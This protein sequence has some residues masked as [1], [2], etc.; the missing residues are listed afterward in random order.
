MK[1]WPVN[2]EKSEWWPPTSRES[3]WPLTARY[4]CEK[5]HH[6]ITS[7]LWTCPKSTLQKSSKLYTQFCLYRLN[8][9]DGEFSRVFLKQDAE[10]AHKLLAPHPKNPMFVCASFPGKERKKGGDPHKLF[11]GGFGVKNGVPNGPFWATESL[12]YCSFLPIKSRCLGNPWFATRF[13]V[14]SVIASNQHS[15]PCL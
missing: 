3:H 4:T 5:Y 1:H 7:N 8:F 10:E 2:G 15:S 14:V 11:P 9:L 12:V 6:S 13:P